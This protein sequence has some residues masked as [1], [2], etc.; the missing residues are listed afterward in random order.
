MKQ[1][2]HFSTFAL[3]IS[4][5]TISCSGNKKTSK[6]PIREDLRGK[7][8]VVS[9]SI[10]GVSA[11]DKLIVTALDDVD[12]ACFV[13]SQW[14]LPNNGYGSYNITKQGCEN[15]SRAILWSY[16]FKNNQPYFNFKFMDGV[17]KSQSKKVEEG[18]TFEVT[19]YDKG[20]FTA[21]SPL[22]FEGKTI[23]IVYNFRKL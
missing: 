7:W 11:S 23:Y 15:G 18:Y 4:I 19:D 1:L 20:H 2:L 16:R 17:K 12:L 9:T 10:E 21:K 6:T 14:N 5:F 8:E 22:S 13:G 3:I